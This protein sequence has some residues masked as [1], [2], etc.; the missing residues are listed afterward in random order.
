MFLVMFPGVMFRT[1][2]LCPGSKNVF[3]SSQKLFCFRA[4]KFVSPTHVSLAAKLGNIC[5]RNNV[6]QFSQ[7][8]IFG[9]FSKRSK[10]Q[11]SSAKLSKQNY[12]SL[13]F[14]PFSSCQGE[15]LFMSKR[16]IHRDVPICCTRALKNC[17]FLVNFRVIFVAIL[18]L[19]RDVCFFFRMF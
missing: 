14:L 4:A 5:I 3:D 2:N 1:Q 9:C 6:S 16:Q 11:F 19:M 15:Q 10:W 7:A 18:E 12:L 17:N 13:H 8:L